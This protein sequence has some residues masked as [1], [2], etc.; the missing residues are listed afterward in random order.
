VIQGE[1]ETALAR[2]GAS[3]T[4]IRVVDFTQLLAKVQSHATAFLHGSVKRFKEFGYL[5]V[6]YTRTGIDDVDMA[7]V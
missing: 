1:P 4:D 5:P 3:I 7:L 6:G 2:C